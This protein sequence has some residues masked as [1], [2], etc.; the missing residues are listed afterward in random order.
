MV[1]PC[2][3]W[4]YEKLF[5]LDSQNQSAALRSTRLASQTTKKPRLQSSFR[6]A[7]TTRR[8]K[9]PRLMSRAYCERTPCRR[10]GFTQRSSCRPWK[11]CFRQSVRRRQTQRLRHSLHTQSPNQ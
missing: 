5:S 3:S 10:M 2:H 7:G 11:N 9:M 8:W 6:E 4:N 1:S